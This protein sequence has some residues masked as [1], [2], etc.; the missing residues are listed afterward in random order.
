MVAAGSTDVRTCGADTAVSVGDAVNGPAAVRG[1]AFVSPSAL[2]ASPACR[3][4]I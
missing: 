1:A 3:L 4:S 2:A